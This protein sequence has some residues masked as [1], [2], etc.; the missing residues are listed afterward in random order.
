MIWGEP[1]NNAQHSFFQLL[2][3]G[4][5][6][7]SMDFLAP[8]NASSRL[9][10]QQD[11]ALANCFAQA[12]AFAFGK[13]EA[14]VRAELASSGMDDEAAGQLAPHKVH[15]GSRP[16]N[17]ILVPRLT[18]RMLGRLVAWYEHKVYVQSVVWDVDPFDQ[19]GVELGKHLAVA[20][21]PAIESPAAA[22]QQPRLSALL[23]HVRRWRCL[24][25]PAVP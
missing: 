3:Q 4:T 19:W 22:A 8:V 5:A 23:E 12:E 17:L 25:R 15:P 24:G 6:R 7:V 11:L 10:G 2:H 20:L 18:P 13:T 9:Q 21:V 14:Q 16:C 1:G